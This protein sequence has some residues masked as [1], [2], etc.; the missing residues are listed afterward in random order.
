MRCNCGGWTTASAK[1]CIRSKR[2]KQLLNFAQ[3]ETNYNKRAKI[4]Q[5]NKTG[6]LYRIEICHPPTERRET[7][8]LFLVWKLTF[9]SI[10]YE[11]IRMI[12]IFFIN[13][14]NLFLYRFFC[15]LLMLR[16]L[17]CV[18][19]Y[20]YEMQYIIG[21]VELKRRGKRVPKYHS[22]LLIHQT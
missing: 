9:A 14:L 17:V 12:I 22:S 4:L 19:F 8:Q 5:S 1:K 20:K 21:F 3:T 15:C 7:L 18:F 10:Y 6:L 2:P 11:Y 13:N 16:L